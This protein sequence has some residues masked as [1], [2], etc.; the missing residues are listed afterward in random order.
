M[1]Y[2]IKFSDPANGQFTIRPYTTNGPASP[3][4]A[5]PLDV[6]AISA[7]TSII[8]QGKGMYDYGESIAASTIHMLENFAA[9]IEPVYPIQG[10]LW[11]KNDTKQMFVYDNGFN[12]SFLIN[13]GFVSPL[14]VNNNR[15][16]RVSTPIAGSDATNKSYV[17]NKFFPIIGGTLT[18]N[19]IMSP[20]T[21]ITV[22]TPIAGFVND[23]AV[24]KLYVDTYVSTVTSGF[25]ALYIL[26]TGDTLTGNLVVSN[27]ARII[28]P[29]PSGGFIT[30]NDV[31][32]KDYVDTQI[33]SST[34]FVKLIGDIITG[35]LEIN[36]TGSPLIPGLFVSNG[37]MSQFD[38]NVTITT[39]NIISVGNNVI[40][41]L[42]T[43]ILN[44]D[45]ANKLYVDTA[46][47]TA[48][49]GGSGQ[50]LTSVTFANNT[51]TFT[52]GI[53]APILVDNVASV[54]DIDFIS[55][56]IPHN[57]SAPTNINSVF[58]SLFNNSGFDY[59]AIPIR[60]V[61]DAIDTLLYD[62]S[63]IN[64]R[65]LYT[66]NVSVVAA[67]FTPTSGLN[68]NGSIEIA[69][70]VT[71]QYDAG[72]VFNISAGPNIGDYTVSSSVYTGPNTTIYVTAANQITSTSTLGNVVPY[73]LSIPFDY[74]TEYNRLQV[75]KG[76]LKL[77]NSTRGQSVITLPPGILEDTP[78]D[79]PGSTP[80]SFNI[81][82]NGAGNQPVNINVTYANIPVT[83][84]DTINDSWTVTSNPSNIFNRFSSIEI[85]N[86]TLLGAGPTLYT[87]K[88][89]V[90][91]GI[92]TIIYVNEAIATATGDGHIRYP[93][94]LTSLLTD[95]RTEL[96]TLYPSPNTPKITLKDDKIFITS[97]MIG[98]GSSVVVTDVSLFSLIVGTT[99]NNDT[100]GT[101]YGYNEP[102]QLYLPSHHI[103]LASL[104][105]G[106][107]L[108]EITYIR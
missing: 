31:V 52:S 18:G 29:T 71:K 50:S 48:I 86:D 101:S 78:T 53:L 102:G 38:G 85:M 49:S 22:P 43:P 65:Y 23:S 37:T 106:G 28:L 16:I 75:F 15:I 84:V 47:T 67:A 36:N 100:I 5:I 76:G 98:T 89:V 3:N 55:T 107:D 39:G 56:D 21:L 108:F 94:T 13:G 20:N 46:I 69:G 8:L 45:A 58:R 61:L 83:A 57:V 90:D 1:D 63:S 9:P 54:D 74:I 4:V 7:S 24:N 60:D 19:L 87:I 40:N 73:T 10:Q 14:D 103:L 11:Y 96:Q 6:H 44:T 104:P 12:A 25:N 34:S 72:V 42:D 97:Q 17:D 59:P 26:K 35:P 51:L 91:D 66:V 93:Y 33:S 62:V 68:V 99:I 79:I 41:D 82:V 2:I 77:Y 105:S 30:G 80:Y 27:N 70:D 64:D 81:N 88:K 95:I 32:N 92:T